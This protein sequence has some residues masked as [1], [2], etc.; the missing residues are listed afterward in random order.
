MKKEIVISVLIYFSVIITVLLIIPFLSENISK[1]FSENKTPYEI[2]HELGKDNNEETNIS[3]TLSDYS[4]T[5]FM[6]KE[7]TIPTEEQIQD[8]IVPKG[9]PMITLVIDDYGYSLEEPVI[10]SITSSIPIT[11]A[12]IPFLKYSKTIN[13]LAKM[14]NKEVIIHLPM[15]AYKLKIKDT[16]YIKKGQDSTEIIRILEK[17]TQE[18]EGVGM[19]NH[20][21][22]EA[23]EDP[24]VMETI[25]RFLKRKNLFFLDSLTTPNSVGYKKAKEMGLVPLKRDVFL[26]NYPSQYYIEDQLR[27]VEKVATKKGYCIA[28]GHIRE[29]TI[30]TLMKWYQD[31][32]SN[33]RFTTLKNLYEEL[34]KLEIS[35]K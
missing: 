29:N 25:I 20:M 27:M 15:E 3:N 6:E 13:N 18:L 22:S 17:A 32:K 34:T 21:G 14:Y 19:N 16:P 5:E 35:K 4:P 2:Y 31:N 26:D 24:E 23:T 28:I 1:V 8:I 10:T 12:I 11:V 33:Y 7:Y 9:K 30:K